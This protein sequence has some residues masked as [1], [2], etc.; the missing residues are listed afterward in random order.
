MPMY[1]VVLIGILKKHF[2][3]SKAAK[4]C[5][6]MKTYVS[7]KG[8]PIPLITRKAFRTKHLREPKE[9]YSNTY[10]HLKIQCVLYVML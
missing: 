6:Q 2:M 5:F 8:R 10:L 7:L 3:V 1:S 9:M 4:L